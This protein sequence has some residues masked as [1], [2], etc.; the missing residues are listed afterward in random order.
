MKYLKF[1]V[2]LFLIGFS[3]KADDSISFAGKTV[4][5]FDLRREIGTAAWRTTQ[6]SIDRAIE[7]KADLVIIH[8]NTYGGMVDAADSIRTKILNCPIPVYVFIDNNAISAGALISIAANKIYMRDGAIIGAATVVNQT[9][10][11]VPDKYQA[12]MRGMMRSTAEAHGKDTIVTG[13]DTTFRWR[14]DPQIAQA[15]VDPTISISGLIDST[16]VLTMT[17]E[18]A[19]RWRFCEGRAEK[20]EDILTANNIVDYKIERYVLTPLEKLI[21]FLISPYLQGLLIML[22]IGGIYFE[23]QTPGIGFP[24]AVS[25]TAALLYFAPLYLEGLASHWELL[26]FIAGIILIAVEIFATPG[27]GVAGIAG[28]VLMVLGLS[29]AM[30]DSLVFEWDFTAGLI[31]VFKS[32]CL[33]VGSALAAMIISIGLGK[34]FLDNPRLRTIMLTAEQRSCEGYISFDNL[35][36]M[37]GS[38]GIARTMLR[39]AGKVEVDGILY[40]AV[41]E[42]GY[43]NADEKIKVIRFE[44]GQLYVM[45]IL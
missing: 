38:T 34:S 26:I 6:Q 44:T 16:K 21:Q 7:I 22:I 23:L 25:I 2:I 14:R 41:C 10:D 31:A 19:I 33:V 28:I 8:M 29:F 32:I 9:G 27:F 3:V 11:V 15:M 43:I 18:E 24:L 20:I 36:S 1:I 35:S 17:T 37:T 40:D 30:V 42:T 5:V 4:Y 12:V 39:P 13:R 45:K